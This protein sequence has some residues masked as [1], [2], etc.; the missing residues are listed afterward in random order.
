M[1]N[2]KGASARYRR[3]APHYDRWSGEPVYCAGR[4]LAFAALDLRAGDTVLD[5][6]C[7]TGLNFA[8]LQRMIGPSG[9]II[10][11]DASSAMLERAGSRTERHRWSNVELI[12]ADA[13]ATAT[14]DMLAGRFGQLDAAVTSYALSLIP[15]WL[16][17]WALMLEL[18]RPGGRLA[19]VD[20]ARP[21]GAARVFSPLA[22][23]ACT[24]G[25][26]DID[27]HPWAALESDC[28]DVVRRSAWGGHI[29][30]AVGTRPAG[31]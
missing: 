1:R 10:G 9:R 3:L 22:R 25:G 26:A 13:G 8:G 11:L 27:A 21:A 24:L 15:E 19:V 31:S 28:D 2:R 30:I 16:D 23:A 14:S 6:G 18:V 17:A 20:M 5:L 4:E 12:V 29:Q 7:G